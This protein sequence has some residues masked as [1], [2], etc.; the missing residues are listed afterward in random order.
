MPRTITGFLRIS[1]SRYECQCPGI[2]CRAGRG[3]GIGKS[4]QGT[5]LNPNLPSILSTL[6]TSLTVCRRRYL[7]GTAYANIR[8]T[9]LFKGT[10]IFITRTVLRLPKTLSTEL[11]KIVLREMFVGPKEPFLGRAHFISVKVEC[12]EFNS[13]YVIGDLEKPIA[14]RLDI[15]VNDR[16]VEQRRVYCSVD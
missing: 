13:A 15:S 8:D 7:V 6:S 1:K 9:A 16:S 14:G 10:G 3:V 11:F 5:V 2:V 4:G 12:C